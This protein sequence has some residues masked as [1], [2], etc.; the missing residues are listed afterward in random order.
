MVGNIYKNNYQKDAI[1]IKFNKKTVTYEELDKIVCQYAGR[2]TKLGLKPGQ[3]VILS[4]PNSPEFIYSY[5]SVV[6]NAGIII[7]TNIQ[8]TLEE[9][10]YFIQD[11]QAN[12]IILHPTVKLKYPDEFFQTHNIKA[13]ILDEEFKQ[14][15]EEEPFEEEPLTEADA[16]QLSDDKQTLSTFLYTSGTTGKQ[17]AA[18]LTHKNLLTNAEQCRLAFQTRAS[19]NHLCVL[20]MF[21]VFGFT[22]CVLNPLWSGSAITILEK[23]QPK[24]VV[25]TLLNEGITVFMGVPSMYILLLETCKKNNIVFPNLR[26][27]VSGGAALPVEVINQAKEILKLSIMEGYGLTE[28]C[29]VICF[30]PLDGVRKDGSIGLPIPYAKCKI[31]DENGV[32]VATGEVGELL[33]QGDNVMLGYLNREQETAETLKDGWLHTGDLAYA[34]EEGYIFIVDRK[35]DMV[36]TGGLNVYPRE[37]E[38]VLYQYP[39]IKETAVVGIGNKLRGEYVKAFIVLKE[40]EECTRKELVKYLRDHI[41]GYKVPREFQFIN[42]LPKN[43]AGKILKRVLQEKV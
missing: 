34:D 5:L 23:F 13:I 30:N 37:V 24:E 17:K 28:A 32:E 33:A 27:G 6:K 8:Q 29:P 7:P 39:K 21:L 4:C 36:I 11:T 35:K 19:D 18:M 3:K 12:F 41:A 20:P 2:L 42:E 9:I 31:A 43:S 10:A 40:G 26:L 16:K 38:E 22:T 15:V 14:A 25:D 1:A